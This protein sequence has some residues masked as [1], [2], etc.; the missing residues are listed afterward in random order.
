MNEG[1]MSD[2][3]NPADIAYTTS[4]MNLK[5]TGLNV[6]TLDDSSVNLV[7]I[8]DSD[9]MHAYLKFVVKPG[10]EADQVIMPD[11]KTVIEKLTAAGIIYGISSENIS[12]AITRK[13]V[14]RNILAAKGKPPVQ[15]G[16]AELVYA[17]SPAAID[18][19]QYEWLKANIKRREEFQCVY[20]RRGQV[21]MEMKPP[22]QGIAGT[23][24]FGNRVPALTGGYATFPMGENV[25]LMSGTNKAI[26]G[27]DGI[28]FMVDDFISILQ[29]HLEQAHIFISPDEMSATL[30]IIPG[31][32][33]EIEITADT[34]RRKMKEAGI[35]YGIKAGFEAQIP[36]KLVVPV[37]IVVA[38]GLHPANGDDGK[39]KVIDR[40]VCLG[41]ELYRTDEHGNVDFREMINPEIVRQGEVVAVLVPPTRGREGITV[42][43]RTIEAKP[44]RQASIIAGRNVELSPDGLAA[45]AK[46][47]GTLIVS[48][49]TLSIDELY[50][51]KGNVGYE[52][53]NITF[54][55]TV[56]VKGDLLPGF[57]ISASGDVDLRGCLDNGSITAGGDVHIKG[58]IYGKDKIRVRAR[59][60][61]FANVAENMRFEAEGDVI[62]ESYLRNCYTMARN[63]VRIINRKK[64]HIMGG[65][66]IAGGDID[67]YDAGHPSYIPTFFELGMN[68]DTK[69]K[70]NEC[71]REIRQANIQ[72][73][74]LEPNIIA[75]KKLEEE[76]ALAP[77][78]REFYR[79]LN[80]VFSGLHRQLAIARGKKEE[81][82]E[83]VKFS[84]CGKLYVR[85]TIYPGVI[86]RMSIFSRAIQEEL[87]NV[88]FMLKD[89]EITC[90]NL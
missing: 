20:V 56:T 34:V 83:R 74:K 19:K 63:D 8:S 41:G 67:V 79:Q 18:E 44:G 26:A 29:C 81:I 47:D 28:A 62:V 87:T 14:C 38:T 1:T 70:Y 21:L 35:S 50:I 61:I 85:G 30:T 90:Q 39:M 72:I 32:S 88:V 27:V 2:Q 80:Q 75:A 58:S 55:G 51:V 64:G 23:D 45:I 65:T 22:T 3:K 77:E 7:L 49:H 86:V 15:G 43:G 5:Q 78:K 31:T 76:G 71:L 12:E 68:P 17:V 59:G 6:I 36:A 69:R 82:E 42:T 73:E 25:E 46:K 24:V 37:E 52:T 33:E 66:V 54:D 13:T 84:N 48:G 10:I 11:L 9:G 4:E 40:S 60:N 89:G 57:Y 16:D 53:G